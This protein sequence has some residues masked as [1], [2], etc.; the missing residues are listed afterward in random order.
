MSHSIPCS[1]FLLL[2]SGCNA[3]LH[4]S[5]PLN[6]T[7]LSYRHPSGSTF[8]VL[9]QRGFKLVTAT[10]TLGVLI[11]NQPTQLKTAPPNPHPTLVYRVKGSRGYRVPLWGMRGRRPGCHAAALAASICPMVAQPSAFSLQAGSS[12]SLGMRGRQSYLKQLRV[13]S[14]SSASLPRHSWE[15]CARVEGRP[16]G[17]SSFRWL[18]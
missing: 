5:H 13:S 7:L 10:V 14:S 16:G 1:S 3:A 18:Q 8:K 2:S 12:R 9:Q 15:C 4:F 11:L 6:S 17:P